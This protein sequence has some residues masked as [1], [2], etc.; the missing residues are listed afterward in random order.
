MIFHLSFLTVIKRQRSLSV[1]Q[2]VL[3]VTASVFESVLSIILIIPFFLLL[4][5]VGQNVVTFVG[6]IP[7][8]IDV[9]GDFLHDRLWPWE[10]TS[11]LYK[12]Y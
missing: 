10:V 7:R 5:F 12:F 8:G 1:E 3:V 11:F 9:D 6:E 2:I 4:L